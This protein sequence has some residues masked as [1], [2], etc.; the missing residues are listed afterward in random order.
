MPNRSVAYMVFCVPH[1]ESLHI[2]MLD[3]KRFEHCDPLRYVPIVRE[4]DNL[5]TSWTNRWSS[6]QCNL[7]AM[8][9]VED[10]DS[11]QI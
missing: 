7:I 5:N 8:E 3:L 6:V 1:P 2:M 9:W 10:V 4:C 11:Q